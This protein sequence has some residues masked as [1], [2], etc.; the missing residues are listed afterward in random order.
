MTINAVTLDT[1]RRL[2]ETARQ[3]EY[4]YYV[5]DDPI[6]P[7]ADYDALFKDI[8]AIELRYPEIVASYSPTQRVGGGLLPH[9]ASVPHEIPM[10]SLENI[11]DDKG[12]STFIARINRRLHNDA[13]DEWD[14][15]CE[16]KLDGLAVALRYEHG[17]LVQALTRGD[18]RV[19]ENVLANVKTIKSIPL[20]LYSAT[21]LPDV[22]EIRGEIFMPKSGFAALNARQ[23]AAGEK[24]FA[25]PRNAAAGSLRQLNTSITASRPLQ[26][27]AYGLGVLS[28]MSLPAGYDETI[29]YLRLLGVPVC[30]LFRV[31]KGLSGLYEYHQQML[32]LRDTLDYDIDGVVFKINDYALQERLGVVSRAPRWAIAY[33]FP[34]QEKSTRVENIGIQVGRTGALTPVARLQPVEVGGVT[35]TNATLHN[36]EELARKDIRIGDMVVVRRAGDVI[37]EVVRYIADFRP[38]DSEA[39]RMPVTCPVCGNEVIKP[40][41]EAVTRCIAG[42][43][44][45]AQRKQAIMHFVSRQAMDIDGLG[46]KLVEQL[47]DADLIKTPV[48]LYGLSA[49]QLAS[50]KR[51]GMKSAQ[52]AIAAIE[53]SKKPLFSRLLYA[54]GIREV[55]EVMAQKLAQHYPDFEALYATNRESL[56]SIKGIGP[57]MAEYIV[58][59][60]ALN[61]NRREIEAL[62][63]AGI[64]IQQVQNSPVSK[65]SF[66]TGKKVVVTGTLASMSRDEAKHKLNKLGAKVQNS[67]SKQTDY[68]I[69]GDKAG[70][71]LTKANDLAIVVLNEKAF[72]SHAG[73]GSMGN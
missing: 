30:P 24:N 37:P 46:H 49:A 19:G 3:Y 28:G 1:Y 71:K 38:A 5:L 21:T 17:L 31:V 47:V 45:S 70:A 62:L 22:I 61:E 23:H 66:F 36:A 32:T 20:K 48:D 68:L 9:F 69:A 25:N 73:I 44:C 2:L 11:F 41:G 50:L 65:D 39:Y 54:L 57:V 64:Q 10:L 35:V 51:M 67:V 8:Q 42:W 26:F 14:Y 6:V 13:G 27:Y 29:V 56:V 63:A 52:N 55:G 59:F 43:N 18:G 72:L 4:H 40:E 12:L 58:R 7:D 60:F 53:A 33:K 15:A 34:A 16:P